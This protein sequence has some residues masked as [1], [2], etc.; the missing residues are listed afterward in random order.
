MR[1]ELNRRR[2]DPLNADQPDIPTQRRR[3]YIFGL[4]ID[5]LTRQETVA[6]LLERID[7]RATTQHV[8]LN[9]SKVLLCLDQQHLARIIHQCAVVNA[10][11]ISVVMAGRLLGVPIP[12]RVTG[13]DL[14]DDLLAAAAARQLRVFM[15]GAEQEILNRCVEIA[16]ARG[17]SICG[18]HHGFWDSDQVIVQQI[19]QSRADILFLAIPSP[20][21]EEFL[22]HWLD[23][24]DVPLAVGVGGSFDVMA[25]KVKRAPLWMQRLGLEWLV[26][27]LQEPRR[28]GR[29]YIV[30]NTRFVW[31]V[32][33]TWLTMRPGGGVTGPA[34]PG[35]LR[36]GQHKYRERN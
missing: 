1:L 36:T 22:A 23:K 6:T 10:D 26:R 9:A 18:S 32:V 7:R 19:A 5:C 31:L 25:G 35:L 16:A 2:F 8:V 17:V 27:L 24:M 34:A 20:R 33:R 3:G 13:I 15:L 11:G 28:L 4:P 14:L 21:K 30:G 12:E 29:R